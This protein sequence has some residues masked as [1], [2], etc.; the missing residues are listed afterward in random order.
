MNNGFCAIL[1]KDRLYQGIAL[2]RSLSHNVKAMK[3]KMFIL[4]IDEE[5]YYIL[6]KM[7][8][9]NTTLVHL[10]EIEEKDMFRLQ[11]ERR[12]NEF[13]WTLKPIFL[14]YILNKYLEINRVTYLDADLCFFSDPAVIFTEEP[15]ADILLTTHDFDDH[16]Q[17]AENDCGRYNSGFISFKR[18][19]NSEHCL[20]WWKEN[21]TIWCYDRIENGRFGDQK[22]LDWI[23]EIFSGV[24]EIRTSGVNIAPWNQMKYRFSIQKGMVHVNDNPLIFYHF[25]GLRIINNTQVV[26]TLEDTRLIPAIHEPYF[27]ILNDIIISV[28]DIRPD[29]S[30]FYIE[31]ERIA[32]GKYHLLKG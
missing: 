25:C 12:M 30:G 24:S 6:Q 10:S 2:Y 9:I 5:V 1:T 16:F 29:F 15:Y 28:S 19:H 27:N 7:N 4:C 13:C 8:L 22:Y 18:G 3:F 26:L 31:K 20:K 21:C 23:P 14:Q 32:T 11:R 17:H